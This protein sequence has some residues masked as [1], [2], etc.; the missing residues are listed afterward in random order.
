MY[1]YENRTNVNPALTDLTFEGASIAGSTTDDS[2]VRHVPACKESDRTKCQAFPLKIAVD[3][4][5]V[6]EIDEDP[7]AVTPDGQRLKEQV[8]VNYYLTRGT[9]KSSVRLVH[10]ATTGYNDKHEAEF[11]PP[12]EPGPVRFFGVL[13]DN[14]GGVSW[15]EGKIIVD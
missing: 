14:R 2:L 1:V 8:W 12:A 4:A 15:L 13:H 10:D 3:P 11:T 7:S 5:T 6:A 9:F